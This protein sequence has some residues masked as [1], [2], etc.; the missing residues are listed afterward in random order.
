MPVKEL[1]LFPDAFPTGCRKQIYRRRSFSSSFTTARSARRDG[2]SIRSLPDGARG[3]PS[4]GHVLR[5]SSVGQLLH[6]QPQAPVRLQGQSAAKA[7]AC[8]PGESAGAGFLSSALVS[9]PAVKR[10]ACSL[11]CRCMTRRCHGPLKRRCS[12]RCE[13]RWRSKL[14]AP[15][16]TTPLAM[17]WSRASP[18]SVSRGGPLPSPAA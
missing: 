4:P 18:M 13:P 10:R 11:P 14:T 17:T 15:T 1:C 16:S 9:G 2:L 7:A 5:L 12:R 8:G 6:V 3:I